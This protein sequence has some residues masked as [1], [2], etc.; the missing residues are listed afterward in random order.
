MS[1]VERLEWRERRRKF[2]GGS[3]APAIMG[4]CPFK[5]RLQI[6]AAKQGIDYVSDSATEAMAWGN[7]LEPVIC[8]ALAERLGEPVKRWDQDLIVIHPT[9]T[10]Q[11]CTPDAF[12]GDDQS[13]L[14]EIKTTNS[15]R[16]ADW[17]EGVPLNYQVQV[18]HN[19]A[20]TGA[21]QALIACLIGGQKLVVHQME[22]RPDFIAALCAAEEAFWKNCQ[23]GIEPSAGSSNIDRAILGELYEARSEPLVF[24]DGPVA[25]LAEVLDFQ[26]ETVKDEL[27]Q[28]G[29]TRDRLENQLIQLMEGHEVA[30]LASGAKWSYKWQTR[31]AYE[32]E[33]C[34]YRVLRRV[35][36]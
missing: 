11:A 32:V 1:T 10:W 20:V 13:R 35:E 21:Q 24:A 8:E 6:W 25:D 29:Q 7:R 31:K 22:P 18:Q 12:V 14:V 2:I 27:K 15:Y 4:V 36:K 9:R 34:K 30:V 26:L 3:D 23:Q 16:G 5:S 33:E 28:L 17:E 19:L